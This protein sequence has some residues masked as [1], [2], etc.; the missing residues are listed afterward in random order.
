[1]YLLS[2]TAEVRNLAGVEAVLAPG[3]KIAISRLDASQEN[4]DLSLLKEDID[5][6]F[7]STDW[8]IKNGGS[9]YLL[10]DEENESGSSS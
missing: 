2:G 9:A 6:F 8:F 4:V 1:V 3:Q 10:D 5:D 7:Q